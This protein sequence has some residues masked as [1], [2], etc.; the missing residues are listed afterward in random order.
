ML[1]CELASGIVSVEVMAGFA[2]PPVDATLKADEIAARRV[3]SGGC[4]MDERSFDVGLK[5]LNAPMRGVRRLQDWLCL[6]CPS[7]ELGLICSPVVSRRTL[8]R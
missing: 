1:T 4:T 5:N 8:C 2:T 6:V 3:E 7:K